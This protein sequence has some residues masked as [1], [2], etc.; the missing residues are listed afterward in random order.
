MNPACLIMILDI[1]AGE[2]S[3]SRHPRRE[4]P[5]SP[6]CEQSD[7]MS[8]WQPEDPYGMDFLQ[9]MSTV[10][11]MEDYGSRIIPVAMLSGLSD[12]G[13][14]EQLPLT[15]TSLHVPSTFANNT[16]MGSVHNRYYEAGAVDV[17]RSPVS[18]DRVHCLPAHAHRLNVDRNR[19]RRSSPYLPSQSRRTSWV[20]TLDDRP[21]TH[22]KDKMVSEL[23]DHIVDPDH[24]ELALD[25]S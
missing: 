2:E 24:E 16:S 23:M 8:S 4:D 25:P 6:G 1:P 3:S 19:R 18:I 15:D 13:S 21:Y 9:H 14:K 12:T 11:R 5:L 20:G 22:L 7:P 10:I 17:M